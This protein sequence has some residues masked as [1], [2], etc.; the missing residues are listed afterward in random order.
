ML[1]RFLSFTLM[2]GM[3]G[4]TA[5]CGSGSP[6]A[7]S[8]LSPATGTPA[9][10]S[11]ASVSPSTGSTGGSTPLTINGREFQ[12]GATVTLEGI[13][14]PAVVADA[15]TSLRFSTPPHAAGIVELVVTNPDGGQGR[16]AGAFSYVPPASFDFD[17]EWAGAAGPGLESALRFTVREGALVDVSCGASEHVAFSPAPAVNMGEFSI[18]APNGSGI[19]ARI[20]SAADAIGTINLPSCSSTNWTAKRIM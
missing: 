7:P 4:V 18:V 17:G 9:P 1:N 16:I 15:G 19:S 13:T 2:A 8:S 20:V 6:S 11:L 10:L 12:N 5:G 14:M 3:A